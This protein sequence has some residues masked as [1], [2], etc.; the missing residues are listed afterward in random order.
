[1]DGPARRAGPLADAERLRAVFH[2]AGRADLAGRLEPA[3][4]GERAAVP[5]RLL[6]DAPDQLGPA[7]VGDRLGQ[8]G[9][10]HAGHAQ[11]LGVDRLVVADQPQSRLVRVIEP[12]I[13]YLAV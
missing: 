1:M 8:P 5:G 13:A 6:S 9:A 12:G 3:H 10:G 11:V 4:L 7:G 2:A